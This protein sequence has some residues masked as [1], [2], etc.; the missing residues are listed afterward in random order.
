MNQLQKQENEQNEIVNNKIEETEED[1]IHKT[2]YNMYMILYNEC[3]FP[4]EDKSKF[5]KFFDNVKNLLSRKLIIQYCEVVNTKL[6]EKKK[7]YYYIPMTDEILF[8]HNNEILTITKER[9]NNKKITKM[10]IF[11]K[12][13]Y[14]NIKLSAKSKKKEKEKPKAESKYKILSE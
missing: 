4:K 13:V 3:D 6:L 2:K 9:I 10:F 1:Q 11:D 7:E 14:N 12:T 8:H 5:K